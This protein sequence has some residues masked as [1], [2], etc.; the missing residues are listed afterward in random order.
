MYLFWRWRDL[1]VYRHIALGVALAA[2]LAVDVAVAGTRGADSS[3][4]APSSPVSTKPVR[5]APR[6]HAVDVASG[7]GRLWVLTRKGRRGPYAVEE[8]TADRL[9]QVR[10]FPVTE[11]ATAVY[12]GAG[13]VWVVGKR[14]ITVLD[15]AGGRTQSRRIEGTIDSMAFARATAYAVAAGRGEVLTISPGRR[16][17][18]HSI[19]ERGGPLALVAVTGAIEVTNQAMNLVPI[20]LGGANTTFLAALQLGRPVIASAGDQAVW[21]RRG[22][23]L[24]RETLGSDNRPARKYVATPGSPLQ[25]VMTADGGCYVSLASTSK[26]RLDLAY[27]SRRALSARHPT[28]T[29]VRAG[30][31]VADFALDPAGGVVL[32]DASGNLRRWVPAT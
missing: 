11:A 14:S 7:H 29:D 19:E 17:S 3:A 16:L 8:L 10:S 5:L 1:G 26:R 15:P 20:I 27:F 18:I 12:Y 6:M 31:R 32:V 23:Q 24:V 4:A 13:R 28:P 30:R 22:H 2:L 25:V 21:V 9:Q